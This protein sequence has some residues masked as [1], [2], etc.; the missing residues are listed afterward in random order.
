MSIVRREFLKSTSV[1]TTGLA[2]ASLSNNLLG[3]KTPATKASSVNESFGLQLYTLRDDLPK[4]P[5]GILQQVASFGY[6]QIEGF[7]GSQGMFWGMKN[8]EFKSFLDSL[9]L[10]MVS[11]HCD[12]NQ[13]F[14]RK[15]DEAAAIGVKYLICPYLGPNK[16][17]DFYKKSA[18]LFNKC[19]DI[20]KQRGMRF[21]YHNH[22]YS[23]KPVEN[24]LPQ[25]VMMQMTNKDSVDYEMDI[26]WVVTAG[27]DPISWFNK[28]PDRFRLGHIKD[29]MTNA[30]ASEGDASVTLGKGSIN[31]SEILSVAR[32]KGMLYFIV[33]QEKYEGTT[34][35]EAVKDNATY[36]K[37]L[38]LS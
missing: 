34:P 25:D 8:T 22:D 5:K 35:I 10:Q 31:Y 14:E 16:E 3:C 33:E 2:L 17:L 18:E 20:C 21:A 26:Y 38:K 9:G 1:L 32:K 37:S 29:R 12:I 30:P 7:E 15:A 19:G 27:Q 6:K 23:F 28:Y 4:D 13:N 24:E 11:S 36:M